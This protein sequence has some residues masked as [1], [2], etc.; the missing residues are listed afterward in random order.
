MELMK[1]SAGNAEAEMSIIMDSLDY[2]LNRLSETGIGIAQNL[3]ERDNM[4]SIVDALTKI[5]EGLEFIT[6]KAGLL[7]SIGLGAGLFAGIKNVG[8]VNY[9]SCPHLNTADSKVF[10]VGTT[11]LGF[12]E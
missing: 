1:D 4:K 11:V 3:F 2:K 10:L 9:I 6:D 7:G 5:G 12:T 8:R